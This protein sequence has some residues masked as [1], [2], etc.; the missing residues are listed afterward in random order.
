MGITV[1]VVKLAI[2][3][4]LMTNTLM[5]ALCH[6]VFSC[7]LLGSDDNTTNRFLIVTLLQQK[8]H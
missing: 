8:I 5:R 4:I 1:L 7:H 2:T 6:S 3:I